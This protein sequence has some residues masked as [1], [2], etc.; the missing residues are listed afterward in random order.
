[1]PWSYRIITPSGEFHRNRRDLNFDPQNHQPH[2]SKEIPHQRS[3]IVIPSVSGTSILPPTRLLM[4]KE[5]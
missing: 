2:E 4:E 3:P 5:M 1:M